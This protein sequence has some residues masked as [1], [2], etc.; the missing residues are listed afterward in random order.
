M[1][2]SLKSLDLIDCLQPINSRFRMAAS[3]PNQSASLV[4]RSIERKM[5]WELFGL[6]PK[7]EYFYE[8]SGDFLLRLK[9]SSDDCT[10]RFWDVRETTLVHGLVEIDSKSYSQDHELNVKVRSLQV[11]WNPSTVIAVQ[12]FLG[13]LRKESRLIALQLNDIIGKKESVQPHERLDPKNPDNVRIST[14]S[15]Q[16]SFESLKICL[17]K[18]HQYRR[19][20]ELTITDCNAHFRTSAGGIAIE[21]SIGD[22]LALDTDEYS[23]GIA[24]KMNIADN[25]RT[26]LSVVGLLEERGCNAFLRVTYQQFTPEATLESRADIP[27]WAKIQAKSSNEVDDVLSVNI[28]TTRFTYLKERTEE[29]LDYL[30]NGLPGKGMGVTS[31]AAKGFISRRIQSRS[32]LQIR[33]VSPQVYIPQHELVMR[34][35][36]LHLGRLRDVQWA[37]FPGSCAILLFL[38]NYFCF[39]ATS[40]LRVGLKRAPQSLKV[41]DPRSGGD[42]CR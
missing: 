41:T 9:G 6:Q 24:E 33:I 34:G 31:R 32:F 38:M 37:C 12:R 7:D 22:L 3:S 1:K 30:S 39:Q 36:V 21:A 15:A 42:F 40:C 5:N 29:M 17:N 25:V 23:V 13:R 26:V 27:E 16:I 19:L 14:L 4:C 20:L 18:E 10:M 35:L 2:L 11:Q 8:A 28:A